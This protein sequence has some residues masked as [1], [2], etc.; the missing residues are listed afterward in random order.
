MLYP[1]DIIFAFSTTLNVEPGENN[2]A[3]CAVVLQ[4]K[5]K[6]SLT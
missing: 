5:Y 3:V 4:E 2:A 1:L 6:L